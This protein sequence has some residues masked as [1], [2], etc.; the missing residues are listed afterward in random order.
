MSQP[1]TVGRYTSINLSSA[2]FFFFKFIIP[3]L[4]SIETAP[5]FSSSESGRRVSPVQFQVFTFCKMYWLYVN[6]RDYIKTIRMMDHIS[7]LTSFHSTQAQNVLSWVGTTWTI[8]SSFWPCRGL[9]KESQCVSESVVQTFL[10]Q[11]AGPT[12]G[13]WEL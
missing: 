8:E 3:L 6:S 10:E 7:E 2:L 13:Y 11:Q 12:L 4:N 5:E 1:V 9:P